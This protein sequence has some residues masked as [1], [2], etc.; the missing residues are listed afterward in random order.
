MSR[1]KKKL[2][3]YVCFFFY[4]QVVGNGHNTLIFDIIN[5]KTSSSSS[6]SSSPSSSS[7]LNVPFHTSLFVCVAGE[8]SLRDTYSYYIKN[9]FK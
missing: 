3:I 1:K 2:R 7:S 6:A 5:T 9:T 8:N 4:L